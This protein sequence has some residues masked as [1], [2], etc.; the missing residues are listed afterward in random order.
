MQ[1][2]RW[3]VIVGLLLA[4]C[5]RNEVAVEPTPSMVPETAEPTLSTEEAAVAAW[6]QANAV[7][8]ST[9]DPTAS[10]E[11]LEPLREIVGDARIVMLGEQTHGTHEFYTMRHRVVRFLV[12]EMGFDA[13]VVEESWGPAKVVNDYVHGGEIDISM[14]LANTGWRSATTETLDMVSWMREYNAE[15]SE[16]QQIDFFGMDMQDPE[17]SIEAVIN[18]LS[19]IDADVA[20]QAETAYAC[21]GNHAAYQALKRSER[22]D[23]TE[24]ARLIFDLI[25]SNVE[26][27]PSGLTTLEYVRLLQ[28]ARIVVRALDYLAGFGTEVRD[29]A[30]AENVAW[31]LEQGGPDRRVILY[32]HNA[33]INL[34]TGWLG[35]NLKTMFGDG[36]VAIGQALYAGTFVAFPLATDNT[37]MQLTAFEAAPASKDKYEHYLNL[38]GYPYMLLDLRDVDSS[39]LGAEWL[40]G[41]RGFRVNGWAAGRADLPDRS[42]VLFSLLEDFDALIFIRDTT[43]LKLMFMDGE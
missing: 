2:I 34:R 30:M 26:Q 41:P 31:V 6:L 21:F 36:V 25:A 1:W 23:C 12:E 10:L 43:P 11:D 38:A 13:L 16:E 19:S 22:E 33:H 7:E 4:G 15:V 18:D 8:L 9:D 40:D 28:E 42:Y 17:P 35:G 29:A 14:A 5:G 27:Y 24:E 32:A 37:V 20:A 39:A 3:V